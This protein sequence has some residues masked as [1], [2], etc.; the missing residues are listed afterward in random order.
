MSKAITPQY[1][2]AEWRKAVV[3]QYAPSFDISIPDEEFNKL[4]DEALDT[5][6]E[7]NRDVIQKYCCDG[8]SLRQIADQQGVGPGRIR[9]ICLRTIH[10][11]C[12]MLHGTI[13]AKKIKMD[14]H[15]AAQAGN[16]KRLMELYQNVPVEYLSLDRRSYH[17]LRIAGLKSVSDVILCVSDG[18]IKKIKD[19]GKASTTRIIH[20]IEQKTPFRVVV[21]SQPVLQVEGRRASKSDF[22]PEEWRKAAILQ[23][24]TFEII[25]PPDFDDIF[26][27]ALDTFPER[28]RD[29]IQ[30]YF[31]DGMTHQQIANRYGV[32]RERIR[33]LRTRTMRKMRS[34]LSPVIRAK[35]D[36]E[37]LRTAAEARMAERW[38]E[39]YRCVPIE[40]LALN[41]RALNSLIKSNSISVTDAILRVSDGSI[42]NIRNCG[43]D[44]IERIIHAIEEKT[45]FRLTV[46]KPPVLVP[47]WFEGQEYAATAENSDTQQDTDNWRI[48]LIRGVFGNN[49]PKK[50]PPDFNASVDVVLAS[51]PEHFRDILIQRFCRG[52]AQSEIAELYG[53]TRETVRDALQRGTIMLR[54]Q[55]RAKIITLGIR[56]LS[57]EPE[58]TPMNA[59]ANRVLDEALL[60]K[61]PDRILKA[62]RDIPIEHLELSAR[63]YN[64]ICM[65]LHSSSASVT[66]V[67]GGISDGSIFQARNCGVRMIDTIIQAMEN[68]TP[69]HLIAYKPPVFCPEKAELCLTGNSK[70]PGLLKKYISA[71]DG[72]K[73]VRDAILPDGRKVD[74]L[75]LAPDGTLCAYEI[76][77]SA[78]E[79]FQSKGH[80]LAGDFNYYVMSQVVFYGVEGAI[81]HGI[82]VLC[83]EY[84]LPQLRRKKEAAKMPRPR[85]AEELKD[86][87]QNATEVLNGGY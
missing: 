16:E 39:L 46:G 1:P 80:S 4:F 84:D 14:L 72:V 18:S 45:P 43:K 61:D 65:L 34:M 15:A 83:P 51:L 10:D 55:K 78:A 86:V 28:N 37:E 5:L 27:D 2:Q 58:S 38:L 76:Y 69:F 40:K 70:L 74:F 30:K 52:L 11:V 44:T 71:S 25:F 67:I 77:N 21:E 13:C 57:E 6:P 68:K 73:W 22:S 75:S 49:L 82:G 81:Q 7:Q 29:V 66:D 3:L 48:A 9:Q 8:M 35:K 19:C 85:P 79:F 36:E 24:A 56:R 41:A 53:L 64:C 17:S 60:S 54:T 50:L 87:F 12:R 31:R 63:A 26:D 20:A 42:V 32:S 59:E 23:N 62:Y 33:Q 47:D